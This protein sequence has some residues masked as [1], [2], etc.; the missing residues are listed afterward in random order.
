MFVRPDPWLPL[1]LGFPLGFPFRREPQPFSAGRS[2]GVSR[3]EAKFQG[4]TAPA[5]VSTAGIKNTSPTRRKPSTWI[6]IRA[7]QSN[8]TASKEPASR[9]CQRDLAMRTPATPTYK[10]PDAS[11]QANAGISSK[12]EIGG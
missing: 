7:P 1:T 8:G 12:G 9:R 3:H 6:N 10:K 5:N 11:R 2:L 4:Q